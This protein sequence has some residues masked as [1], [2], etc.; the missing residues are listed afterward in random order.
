MKT[1]DARAHAAGAMRRDTRGKR[2]SRA[3]VHAVVL[4]LAFTS[5]APAWSAALGLES[6]LG[7][8]GG[9]AFARAERIRPFA[10]PADHGP[11]ERFRSEWWYMTATLHDASDAPFGVQFTV[12]RQATTAAVPDANP[13]APSQ[14]YLAHFA[15]TDVAGGRHREAERIA[16]GHPALAGARAA[17]FAVWVDGWSISANDRDP[18]SLRLNAASDAMTVDLA[19]E[20]VK[21]IVLQGDRGLSAKGPGQAS[22][23][24]SWPRL[25]VQGGLI[26]GDVHHAVEG[27][28]WFDREW[29][30]SVL[31]PGQVGW[32]WFGLQ[33]DSGEDLMAFRLRRADGRRDPYD[34]GAWIDV[35]GVATPLDWRAFE[36]TPLRTWRD[37][38]GVE[39]PVEWTVS[40]RLAGGTRSLRIVA[41]LD[42]QRMDTLLTY[43]EGLVRIEDDAGRR[44]GAGYMELTGYER[45]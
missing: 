32:D 42:D 18:R 7:E 33:L 9:A 1:C 11:H 26:L 41:E 17:P 27:R 22:Y 14:V 24:Y 23:Y 6:V 31:G 3:T 28:A 10:F 34:H 8:A 5:G 36:L 40:V 35:A 29:S 15:V 38:R 4:A 45:P 19:L 16:R 2:R 37:E 13:W 44:V 12:F 21:P 30:T 25:S 20:P 43:W 39:W